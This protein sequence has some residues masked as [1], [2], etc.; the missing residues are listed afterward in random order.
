MKT[1]ALARYLGNI[2]AKWILW[3]VYTLCIAFLATRHE[4]WNDEYHVWFLARFL[5]FKE[6]WQAMTMEGHFLLWF[7][8]VRL[9]AK[10][11]CSFWCLH[12]LSVLL[13]SAAAWLLVMKAPFGM[14]P[15]ALALFSYP[16]I[17]W[18]P[19]ISRCYALIPILLFALA[20]L[21]REN[22]H[23]LLYAVLVGLLAHTHAYMEGAVAA[24]FLLWCHE[25]ILVPRRAGLPV[26]QGIIG[27][28][29]ILGFVALAFLQVSG[30]L[31]YGHSHL[32]MLHGVF[33]TWYPLAKAY[34]PLPEG[35][36]DALKTGQF[37]FLAIF[38]L[39]VTAAL[40]VV[41]LYSLARIFWKQKTNR[42]FAWVLVIAVAWQVL[43]SV[44]V[45]QYAEH[46]SYLPMLLVIFALWC[47]YT[48]D[49]RREAL[50]LLA[51]LFIMTIQT[52]L[53]IKDIRGPFCPD[54]YVYEAVKDHAPLESQ[55]FVITEPGSNPV[56]EEYK[57]PSYLAN[58]FSF[59]YDVKLVEPPID[60]DYQNYLAS[61]LKSGQCREAWCVLIDAAPIPSNPW[62][63][64]ETVTE[65]AGCRICHITL[66]DDNFL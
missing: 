48:K 16:L 47:V 1:W 11:G 19:V 61:I 53:I 38:L 37:S 8:P 65:T 52:S 27:A 21:Y 30:S 59:E 39:V 9:L 40:V 42:K 32:D 2:K 35:V 20:C 62:Y 5:S 60:A 43:M 33:Q 23:P 31:A 17:Y 41:V 46:R 50:L 26:R 64:C 6:L 63:S 7:L 4:F 15:K 25:R 45:Y 57:I 28:A 66:T 49:I 10:L 22:R 3:G 34:S 56:I 29:V 14:L 44:A 58:M 54:T 12:L 55:L 18:F 36:E 13:V 51:A 24:L